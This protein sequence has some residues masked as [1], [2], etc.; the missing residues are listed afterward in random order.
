MRRAL[1]IVLIL[2]YGVT[3]ADAR[4]VGI[5]TIAITLTYSSSRTTPMQG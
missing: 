1:L 2:A 4:R 5:T 3:S